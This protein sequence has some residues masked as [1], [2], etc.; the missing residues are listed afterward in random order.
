MS[1]TR[2][3]NGATSAVRCVAKI[4][5]IPKAVFRRLMMSRMPLVPRGSRWLVG[6]SRSSTCGCI[7]Q[8]HAS[9]T[10]CFSPPESSEIRRSWKPCKPT[11]VSASSMRGAICSGGRAR[12]S[13]PNAISSSTRVQKSCSSGFWNKSPTCRHVTAMGCSA[14]FLPLR[15]TLPLSVPVEEC[16]I[17]PFIVRSNVDLPQPVGPVSNT[18]SPDATVALMPRSVGVSRLG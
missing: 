5:V 15:R 16:G 9:A 8:K 13:S 17:K 6:S 1:Q 11:C 12:F 3:H 14:T 10:R 4:V 18:K 2:V 7:A